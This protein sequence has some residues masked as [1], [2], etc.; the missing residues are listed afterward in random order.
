[1]LYGAGFRESS[2]KREIDVTLD[3][4]AIVKQVFS[5]L[6]IYRLEK[7][8]FKA[9]TELVNSNRSHELALRGAFAEGFWGSHITL[10]QT[11][12]S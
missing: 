9:N 11:S 3:K 8:N 6:V 1:M 10:L 7:E 5:L 4:R 12:D 2:Y